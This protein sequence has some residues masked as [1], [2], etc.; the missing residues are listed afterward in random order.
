QAQNV[1]NA[2]PIAK[3][4]R[5]SSIEEIPED[6]IQTYGL[7]IKGRTESKVEKDKMADKN[8]KTLNEK[9]K[10]EK[11]DKTETAEKTKTVKK[12]EKNEKAEN[13]KTD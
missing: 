9:T 5:K 10:V 8:A 7:K 12:E 3:E 13:P 4:T 11:E 2:E 1:M 6:I